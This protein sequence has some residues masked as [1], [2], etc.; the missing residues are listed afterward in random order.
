MGIFDAEAG[1]S[2]ACDTV[3][4]VDTAALHDAVLATVQRGWLLSFGSSRDGGAVSVTVLHDDG[5][6]RLWAANSAELERALRAV[7]AAADGG[8]GTGHQ[9]G[10]VAAP[11]GPVV[12]PPA[13]QKAQKARPVKG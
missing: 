12:S 2:N 7:V 4:C 3:A 6:E 1:E 8:S 13:G 11:T 9:E 10:R 5:K